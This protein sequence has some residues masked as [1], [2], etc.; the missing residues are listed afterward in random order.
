MKRNRLIALLIGMMGLFVVGTN[1]PPQTA[2][3]CSGIPPTLEENIERATH[4]V[5]A[6]PIQRD[7]LNRNGSLY[8]FEYL[9]G[10]GPSR[11][12]INQM[13]GRDIAYTQDYI[14]PACAYPSPSSLAET[15]AIYL[16]SH[17]DD[18]SYYIIASRRLELYPP[19]IPELQPTTEGENEATDKEPYQLIYELTG[20]TPHPP[21]L[22]LPTPLGSPL[23]MQT[24]N[25]TL[26]FMPVDSRRP[27]RIAE[28]VSYVTT[29]QRA[30]VYV[31]DDQFEGYTFYPQVIQHPLSPSLAVDLCH[32][33]TC[34]DF[35]PIYN[36]FAYMLDAHTIAI[37]SNWQACPDSDYDNN[38]ILEGDS[39]AFSPAEKIA[40]WNGDQ[41]AI[42]GLSRFDPNEPPP[43]VPY[44][45]PTAFTPQSTPYQQTTLNWGPQ[46]EYAQLAYHAAWSPDGRWLSFADE[47]GLWLWDTNDTLST[48]VLAVAN[49]GNDITIP[50]EF[51]E[52][53]RYLHLMRNEVPLL[54]EMQSHELLP[55][56]ILAYQDTY[57]INIRDAAFEPHY[58][59]TLPTWIN[60]Q[61]FYSLQCESETFCRIIASDYRP[62]EFFYKSFDSP[63]ITY[64]YDPIWGNLVIL[65][66]V[67]AYTPE[68]ENTVIFLKEGTLE[69]APYLDSP[70]V[71]VEWLPPFFAGNNDPINRHHPSNP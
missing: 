22:D 27:R 20:E 65:Y 70:L 58:T 66:D 42:H 6:F 38:I 8:V 55:N 32:H 69:L 23:W 61:L 48:P 44:P 40:I 19:Q 17:N 21:I 52:T 4:I 41:L 46:D 3:A 24:E 53:G 43:Y 5:Y 12:L 15:P 45:P 30:M 35:S 64:D 16:L 63:T 13:D 56:A 60:R 7:S 59:I 68:R 62:S 31:T 51:S 71:H 2:W 29:S 25:D 10:S 11:L 39:F 36:Y 67:K 54:L 26:Y 9:K 1:H 49:R 28:K 37:C 34:A 14:L 57:L 33:M 47:D 50:T 18:G